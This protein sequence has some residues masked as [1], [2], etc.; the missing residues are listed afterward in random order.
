MKINYSLILF[1]FLGYNILF[2]QEEKVENLDEVIITSSRIDIPFN[3][4][5]RTITIISQE[6]ILKNKTLHFQG[7]L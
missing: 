5:S 3:E 1:L 6:D 2:S 4:N 7:I